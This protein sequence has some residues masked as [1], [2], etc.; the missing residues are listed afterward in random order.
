[1]TPSESR[2]FPGL[3]GW[4]LPIPVGLFCLK[5]AARERSSL[6]EVVLELATDQ[7]QTLDELLAAV[8][9]DWGACELEL[10]RSVVAELVSER[11]LRRG[12]D[13]TITRSEA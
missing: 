13:D 2:R 8:H 12:P 5:S 7:P 6:R 1:M 10:L 9:E 4:R 11:L 3:P